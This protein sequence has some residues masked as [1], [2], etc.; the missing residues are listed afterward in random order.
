MEVERKEPSLAGLLLLRSGGEATVPS[1]SSSWIFRKLAGGDTYGSLPSRLECRF[2]PLGLLPPRCTRQDVCSDSGLSLPL[3]LP[4]SSPCV[5]TA[6]ATQ[7]PATAR[8][9]SS[10]CST[11]CSSTASRASSGLCSGTGST[12]ENSTRVSGSRP[13][14]PRYSLWTPSVPVWVALYQVSIASH[15]TLTFRRHA[16]SCP[17]FSRPTALFTAA[18]GAGQEGHCLLLERLGDLA[19]VTPSQGLSGPDFGTS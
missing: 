18:A 6:G 12:S 13:P 11:V 7:P 9:P 3:C 19:R 15:A 8:S 4:S 17:V 14:A 5:R 10:G 16:I 1:R 2:R